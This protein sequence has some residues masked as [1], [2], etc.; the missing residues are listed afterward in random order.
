MGIIDD[1]YLGQIGK[2]MVLS[3]L[4]KNKRKRTFCGFTVSLWIFGGM[5]LYVLAFIFAKVF[6]GV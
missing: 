6:L 2:G 1:P 3:L 4:P 5:I